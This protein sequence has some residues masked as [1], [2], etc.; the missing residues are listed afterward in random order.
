MK[1]K[2]ELLG[3]F[4]VMYDIGVCKTVCKVKEYNKEE[5]EAGM[6]ARLKTTTLW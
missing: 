4:W 5:G 3:L 6:M 2:Q 1:A